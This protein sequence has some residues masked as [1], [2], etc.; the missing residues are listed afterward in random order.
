MEDFD[1]LEAQLKKAKADRK[2]ADVDRIKIAKYQAKIT[3]GL[4]NAKTSEDFQKVIL[5]RKKANADWVKAA[6]DWYRAD[7][8]RIRVNA[9]LWKLIK[10]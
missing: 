4:K 5:A 9:L 7:C 3:K 8:E 6:D 2:K 1:E 10:P